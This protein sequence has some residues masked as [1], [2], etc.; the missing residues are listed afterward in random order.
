MDISAR[1]FIYRFSLLF[2][3][4]VPKPSS[5]MEETGTLR[6]NPGCPQPFCSFLRYFSSPSS[7]CISGGLLQ[8]RQATPQEI[9][10]V[11]NHALRAL[12][13]IWRIY[14]FSFH[15]VSHPKF[16]IIQMQ[17]NLWPATAS[18]AGGNSGAACVLGADSI[19]SSCMSPYPHPHS[20]LQGFMSMPASPSHPHHHHHHP[21][22]HHGINGLYS[23][24]SFPGGLGPP[25]IEGPE[26]DYKP[27]GL[28]ALRMKAKEPG[29][30]ISWP[31]WPKVIPLAHW[32]SQSTH[33]R[34][35][36]HRP[37]VSLMPF[38]QNTIG[39]VMDI[40]KHGHLFCHQFQFLVTVMG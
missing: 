24:H 2:K 1:H 3:G 17:G 34:R 13:S 25:A 8:I 16:V 27:T 20:N 15:Q 35:N 14:I 19:P 21:P 26:G 37:H 32:L 36:T 38:S 40:W 9:W 4:V 23:L 12:Y 29:S 6:E 22:H 7:R 31:T 30:I 18:A 10:L 33:S 5:Q 28:V 11:S 39:K